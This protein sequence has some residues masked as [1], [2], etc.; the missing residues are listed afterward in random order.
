[1]ALADSSETGTIRSAAQVR[2]RAYG[3]LFFIGF[4]AI[5]IFTGLNDTHHR[6]PAMMVFAGAACVLLLALTLLL[7]RRANVLPAAH[8][9]SDDERRAQRMFRAV[10]IIQWVSVGTAIAI[11]DLLAMPEYIVPAIAI[12]VGLHLFPLAGSFHN[13][14]HYVTGSL[15]IGWSLGCL[16]LLSRERVPGITA[17]GTGTVLLVSAAVTLGKNF[18]AS[19]AMPT[20]ASA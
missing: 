19:A 10:N 13:R 20:K 11:L 12:I 9:D 18:A 7:L 1:M 6:S 3:C 2:S 4:G 8:P 17:L 16:A 14:Q 15:L 5:W